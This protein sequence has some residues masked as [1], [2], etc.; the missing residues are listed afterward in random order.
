MKTVQ[1]TIDINA[2]IENLQY[3][4]NVDNGN[5]IV[6]I[7]FSN[8][9]YGDITAIKFSV[10]GY[11][12]FGD[13]VPVNGKDKFFLIIQDIMIGKNENATNLKAKLPNQDM[14]KLD[15][16]ECQ[17]CYADGTVASYDGESSV[18]FE[19]ERIDNSEQLNALH[20][21]Y[22]ENAKFKPKD[23]EQGWICS[24]GRFNKHNES[25]CSLCKKSKTSTVKMCSEDNLRKL[26]EEYKISEEK[27]KKDREV[28]EKLKEKEKK[29]RN[30]VIGIGVVIA[31]IFC[32][33]IGNSIEM[34]KREIYTSVDEMREAM[35]GKWTHYYDGYYS[36][37]AMWQWVIEGDVAYRLYK[38]GERTNGRDVI[39]NPKK[40]S[41]TIGNYSCVVQKGGRMFTE[42][43]DDV[44]EKGG[45]LSSSDTSSTSSS[46]H[47]SVYSALQFTDISITSNSSY[48]VCTGKV[49]N[50]GEKTYK[51][52]T[53]K[54]SFK[55]ASGNVLD[56]DSTYA[57]GSE[58]LASGESTS[59]RMSVDK[60]LKIKECSISIIN[61]D[62]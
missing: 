25:V 35:Q 53:I 49:K 43:G 56:T 44:F 61:Y 40:G 18:S 2:H 55:D 10:C 28:E 22:D 34:S 42:D 21:L 20:K 29:K 7:S 3:V 27:D 60:D 52:V 17:I 13:I 33:L 9:G 14:K 23:F 24:C 15:L 45:Y 19:L 41:F 6:K 12:S 8:L 39:W 30:I 37:N 47:E 26:V 38:D 54:G 5:T 1:K 32:F 58:G 57:V 59:F 11:N 31:I 62:N 51:F 16:V 36:R 46:S 4:I 50:N 48:T